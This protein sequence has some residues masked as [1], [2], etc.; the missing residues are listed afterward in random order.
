MAPRRCDQISQSLHNAQ[1]GTGVHVTRVP[2]ALFGVSRGKGTR[3]EMRPDAQDDVM[4][5]DRFA[6][7][8][9]ERD[10]TPGFGTGEQYK[11][12]VALT[13]LLPLGAGHHVAALRSRILAKRK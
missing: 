5:A 9:Y 8:G 10:E 2:G 1:T 3:E 13:R 6:R 7:E 12:I 11:T 4:S